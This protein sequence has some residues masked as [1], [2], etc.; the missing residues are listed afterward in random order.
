LCFFNKRK[1]DDDVVLAG[2]MYMLSTEK[3][4]VIVNYLGNDLKTKLHS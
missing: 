4:K 3:I 2:K 1:F